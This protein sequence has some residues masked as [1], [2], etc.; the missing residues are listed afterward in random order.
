MHCVNGTYNV[1]KLFCLFCRRSVS[2]LL[3]SGFRESLDSLIRSYVQRQGRALLDWDLQRTSPTPA[4]AEDLDQQREDMDQQRDD[5]R[6]D[7][8]NNTVRPPVAIPSPPVPPRQPLWH[9]VLYR[10][11]WNRRNMHRTDIVRFIDTYTLH[12]T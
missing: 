6:D 10:N 8:D 2:N 7:R 12:Q 11:S 5:P 1:L 4:S 3:H 9:S